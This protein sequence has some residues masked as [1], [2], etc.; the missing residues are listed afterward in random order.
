MAVEVRS[1]P[2]RCVPL[3]AKDRRHVS[4][5]ML[6]PGGAQ[7]ITTMPLSSG[8][9]RGPMPIS[10]ELP[11]GHLPPLVTPFS[12]AIAQLAFVVVFVSLVQRVS[13]VRYGGEEPIAE[14]RRCGTRVA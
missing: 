13:A 2:W 3:L 7:P 12:L 5:D 1:E 10:R 8:S 14:R 9:D 6:Y 4:A 11:H